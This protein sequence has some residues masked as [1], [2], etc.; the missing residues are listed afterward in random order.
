MVFAGGGFRFGIYLG[1]YAA[2]RDA[3]RAPDVLLATCGGAIAAALVQAL[4][5]DAQRKAWLSSQQMYEFWGSLQPAPQARITKA[6]LG[7]ARRKWSRQPAPV[8]PDLFRDYLFEVPPVLPLPPVATVSEVDVVTIGGKLLFGPAD[9][10]QARGSR[11][12]FAQTVFGPPRAAALVQGMASPFADPRWGEHAVAHGVQA[13]TTLP[14]DA[15]A[16][17][18]ITDFY[19]FPTYRHGA[20]HYIGGVVD[21]FPIELAHRLADA[22]MLEFK[23]SFNQHFEIPAW[24][25]VLGLDGNQRLRHVNAQAADVWFDTSDVATALPVQPVQ[26]QLEWWRNRIVLAQPIDY[27]AYVQ[28]M[29]AQWQYG[30]Q[31]GQE[32]LQRPAPGDTAGMRNADQYNRAQAGVLAAGA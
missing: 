18:A 19:Y 10:G 15:A 16:R 7:A 25:A 1:M 23:E 28:A 24:R 12:L 6:L 32:A 11:K 31:R 30:Y 4:P 5:D 27:A 22:V 9:V 13:D 21:L 20:D 17:M 8:V 29:D 26:R 14:L 2:A 3:G